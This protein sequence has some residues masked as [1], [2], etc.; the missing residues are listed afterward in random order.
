[1]KNTAARAAVA[2]HH[3]IDT[4]LGTPK[5]NQKK[6]GRSSVAGTRFMP[7]P[8]SKRSSGNL[9]LARSMKKGFII[10]TTASLL[11]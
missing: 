3:T 1:M 6:N 11:P 7:A 10:G 8:R 9:P 4:T 5:L 2:S